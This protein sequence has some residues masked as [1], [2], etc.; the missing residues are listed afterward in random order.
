MN[1]LFI[2][3]RSM[4]APNLAHRMSQ[5][6]HNV[7]LYFPNPELRLNFEG[8]VEKTGDWQKELPW[9]GKDGLIV[10]D[11]VG[12]GKIQE[13]LR[14]Q[15]FSVF[16][17]SEIGCKLEADRD[18]AQ[19]VLSDYGMKTVEIKTFKNILEAID[20]V[21]IHKGAW[22]IKQNGQSSKSLNYVSMF[23]DGHDIINVLENY[24]RIPKYKLR[25]ITLQRKIKGVEIGVGRYFNGKDWVGPIEVNI[26]HKK[27]FPGDL[28]PPTSEMG[29][30]G[31]YDDDEENRLFQET[32]AKLKPFLQKIDYRGDIDLNC[33]VNEKGA[34]P[35]EITSRLGAPIIH[36]HDEIHKSHWADFLKAIADGKSYN[37]KWRRGYGIVVMLTVPPFPYSNKL[38]EFTPFGVNIY[39]DKKLAASDF[40][41]IHFEEVALTE[42][43]HHKQYYISGFLGYV[44][45]VTAM[46]STVE[47]AQEKAYGLIRKIYIPKMFYRNDIGSSFIRE[48]KDRLKELG[49]SCAPSHPFKAL[50][51]LIKNRLKQ[52]VSSN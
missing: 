5:E 18:Y 9:V 37:L 42:R 41:H 34:F 13:E 29:T 50:T 45:Y 44:M 46:G 20:F 22:V 32:L 39:F 2:S 1:I 19:K 51:N 28:G 47:E 36:L 24:S 16:G 4:I 40:K 3:S 7:K 30:L 23:D 6:G 12:S 15:G 25:T 35:L 43:N 10:F 48:N 14:Y 31:W 17:G 52:K 26:E 49:Y 21:K 33:I 11:D 27:L 8:M 38:K